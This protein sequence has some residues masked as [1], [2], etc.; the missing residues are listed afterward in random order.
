[1][2]LI[3][4]VAKLKRGDSAVTKPVTAPEARTLEPHEVLMSPIIHCAVGLKSWGSFAGDPDLTNLVKDLQERVE[5][6]QGGDMRSVEAMLYGQAMTLQ[7]IFT[8]LARRAT[9][10]E[11]LKQYQTYLSLALKAQAQS[12]ATLEALAEIKNPRPM[13]FVKQANI[14]SGPQQVNNGMQTAPQAE[15]AQGGGGVK[16]LPAPGLETVRPPTQR[17][18]PLGTDIQMAENAAKT[19]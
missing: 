19:A 9:S 4:K 17:I 18:F 13:A 8:S 10:Q 14:S 5:N 1:L 12:R 3:T 2:A 15:S 11:Y 7:T 16:S 6:V